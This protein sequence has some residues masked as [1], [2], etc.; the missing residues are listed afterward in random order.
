MKAKMEKK[1]EQ[2]DRQ[3]GDSSGHQMNSTYV[4]KLIKWD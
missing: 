3:Q 4:Y 1:L 2:E